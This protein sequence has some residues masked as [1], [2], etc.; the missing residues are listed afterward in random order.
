MSIILE[1]TLS[2]LS[3]FFL[4]NGKE[5]HQKNKDFLS[6]PTPKIPGKEG[7]MLKKTRNSLQGRKTR[8]SK[9]N[10]ERKDRAKLHFRVSWSH[11]NEL[12]GYWPPPPPVIGI[13]DWETALIDDCAPRS[14][15]WLCRKAPRAKFWW[16]FS[17]TWAKNAAKK[18]RN[19]S[20]IFVLQFPGKVGAINFTRNWRQIRL[21]VK[22][23]I[24][25][26]RDSGSLGEAYL[27]W[28]QGIPP[29]KKMLFW[30]VAKHGHQTLE[31][32]SFKRPSGLLRNALGFVDQRSAWYV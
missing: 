22:Y 18:W 15:S 13:C 31:G 9:K 30:H 11:F 7:K 23:K 17:P 12:R 3:L 32:G 6:L 29:P 8:N 16:N 25:S 21:A 24:L 19:V 26:P 2:F 10:T 5:N 20:P 14:L 28:L 1:S 4:E 27:E